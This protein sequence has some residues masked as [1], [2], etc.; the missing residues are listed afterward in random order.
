MTANVKKYVY[1]MNVMG[2]ALYDEE[3]IKR[4]VLRG[5]PKEKHD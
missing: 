5:V 3:I 4:S 1:A 2:A